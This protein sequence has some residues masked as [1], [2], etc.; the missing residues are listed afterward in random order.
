MR[1]GRGEERLEKRVCRYE[2]GRGGVCQEAG[3]GDKVKAG[4][5]RALV[6]TGS[7]RSPSHVD[8][9]EIK[10]TTSWRRHAKRSVVD[11]RV[12]D[13]RSWRHRRGCR[14]DDSECYTSMVVACC[15]VRQCRQQL[16]QAWTNH[17][18]WELRY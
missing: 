10:W 11:R 1:D 8:D 15:E 14:D 16:R 2:S 5:P 12:D 9:G 4:M 3:G 7:V 17:N 13:L 18:F 6:W